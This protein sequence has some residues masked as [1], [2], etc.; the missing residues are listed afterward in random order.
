MPNLVPVLFASAPVISGIVTKAYKQPGLRLFFYYC[1]IAFAIELSLFATSYRNINNHILVSCFLLFEHVFLCLNFKNWFNRKWFSLFVIFV[2]TTFVF[3]WVVNFISDENELSSWVFFI[4]HIGLS[5]LAGIFLISYTIDHTMYS[6]K[7]YRFWISAGILLF[8]SSSQIMYS[9][10][11]LFKA[12]PPSSTLMNYYEIFTWTLNSL[13][14]S[15]YS[16]AF[17]C[18]YRK[19]N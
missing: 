9:M 3:V 1:I 10:S 18:Q 6:L 8:M 5:I 16:Y 7:D 4:E 19:R 11:S 12:N 15:I 2:V 13:T 14:Y 17:L